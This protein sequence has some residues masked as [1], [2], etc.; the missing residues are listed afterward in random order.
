MI[1]GDE[2]DSVGAVSPIC[3]LSVLLDERGDALIG[4]GR[5]QHGLP[6]AWP[7]RERQFA[8]FLCPVSEDAS[9]V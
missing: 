1:A 7:H 2:L 9:F 6:L 5:P 4:I 3:L 8:E